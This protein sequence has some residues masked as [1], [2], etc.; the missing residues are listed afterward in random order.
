VFEN[1]CSSQPCTIEHFVTQ[2]SAGPNEAWQNTSFVVHIPEPIRWDCASPDLF[3]RLAF[4]VSG[5]TNPHINEAGALVFAV[6]PFCSGTAL[7]E[8]EVVDSGGTQRGGQNRSALQKFNITI[9]SVD[10][11]PGFS[12]TAQF[13]PSRLVPVESSDYTLQIVNL[14][15]PISISTG[16][17]VG[18]E[19]NQTLSFALV[20]LEETALS[21][22]NGGS[23][24]QAMP[25]VDVSTGQ[26]TFA[27]ADNQ[28]GLASLNVTL[29]DGAG[30]S[31]TEAITIECTTVNDPPEVTWAHQTFEVTESSGAHGPLEIFS[32]VHP[33]FADEQQE[34]SFTVAHAGGHSGLFSPGGS[35][36]VRCVTTATDLCASAELAFELAPLRFGNATFSVVAYDSGATGALHDNEADPVFFS[37][38]V[39][40]VNSAPSFD[41]PGSHFELEVNQDSWCVEAPSAAWGATNCSYTAEVYGAAV[42][43]KMHVRRS[44]A[45]SIR[46][47]GTADPYEIR[48]AASYVLDELGLAMPVAESACPPPGEPCSRQLGTFN[49]IPDDAAVAAGL[50]VVM[51][52]VT[53][54][55]SLVFGLR[56]STS[57]SASFT[58][59]LADDGGGSTAALSSAAHHFS[60]K[61]LPIN[62]PPSYSL[63]TSNIEV[64]PYEMPQEI[65]GFMQNVSVGP[66][67]EA[68]QNFVVMLRV[69]PADQSL[70]AAGGLPRYR[71]NEDSLFFIPAATPPQSTI[72]IQLEIEMQDTGGN[73][74]WPVPAWFPNPV[75]SDNFTIT[76]FNMTFIGTDSLASAAGADWSQMAA[77][78]LPPSTDGVTMSPRL[79]H[80][81]VEFLGDIWVLGGYETGV[82]NASEPWQM[83]SRRLLSHGNSPQYLL[84]DVWRFRQVATGVCSGQGLCLEQ[85]RV[86]T[87]AAWPGR[88]SHAAVVMGGR[89]WIAGGVTGSGLPARDV[90]N[91]YDGA[92][93][94]IA[95]ALAAWSP[96]FSMSLEVVSNPGEPNDPGVLVLVGGGAY[97]GEGPVMYND[98]WTSVDG[99]E[100][101]LQTA[102][103]AWSPRAGHAVAAL[104]SPEGDTTLWL[105][106]GEEVNGDTKGDV[107]YSRDSGA[108]WHMMAATAPW[109]DRAGHVM[110]RYQGDLLL[111]GGRSSVPVNI[112]LTPPIPRDVWKSVN[113]SEWERVA[114]KAS[115]EGREDFGAVV[116]RASGRVVLIGGQGLRGRLDE[117]W[118]SPPN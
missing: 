60:I 39:R 116:H 64:S 55:G 94:T 107:W 35:P 26:L 17:P 79:G 91:S 54:D 27:I 25:A 15:D 73:I 89:I 78:H 49:V 83:G 111:M 71:A 115:F 103:A 82:E 24:F 61:V 20:T 6:Q 68:E 69:K 67:D 21:G 81:V 110:V 93:W 32:S 56:D 43:P 23:L 112:D 104:R 62:S 22:I 84:S 74:R 108:S 3:N 2:F 102:S 97:T 50:F 47:G 96:R 99:V 92:S 44:F 42:Q 36:T 87:H 1:Q 12:L 70:F 48:G 118:I 14:V 86:L 46:M 10:Q 57:G 37:L 19:A 75:G 53:G 90:W 52:R 98:V 18:F 30:L 100:W 34:I 13:L 80:A 11:R 31:Y 45:S 38:T 59:S 58:V 40:P 16:S 85:A 33:G 28:F 72:T 101:E 106:G 105:T 114:D 95:T 77:A 117:I 51:P 63:L 113:G 7:V 5:R 109:V 66:P 9:S 4:A 65:R 29:R 88:H 41:L 8:M 76:A